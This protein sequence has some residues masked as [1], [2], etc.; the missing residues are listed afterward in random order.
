MSN[1][2]LC[3]TFCFNTIVGEFNNSKR[4]QQKKEKA[5]SKPS[6]KNEVSQECKLSLPEATNRN[7]MGDMN[8]IVIVSVPSAFPVSCYMFYWAILL[9]DFFLCFLSHFRFESWF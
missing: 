2:Y 6:F 4:K 9:S 3:Y 1:S 8:I 5:I 7:L